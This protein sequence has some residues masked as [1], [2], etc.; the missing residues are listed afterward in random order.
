MK[1]LSTLFV[2]IITANLSAF[3]Y[4]SQDL[5]YDD[6]V[7][8]LNYKRNR[9][10]KISSGESLAQR[11]MSF[12]M[13]TTLGE[14]ETPNSLSYPL[15]QGFEIGIN[16][17]LGSQDVEGR[18]SFRY[19]FENQKSSERTSLRE[20]AFQV[21][22]TQNYSKSWDFTFGGGFSLRHLLHD[23]SSAAINEVSIQL[24]AMA[25]FE[26]RLSPSSKLA[27]EAGTRFPFGISGRDRLSLDAGIKL[28]TDLE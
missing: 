19:F 10:A 13:V 7:S 8:E 15:L 6:L 20:F 26:T 17:D 22:K 14:I 16:S 11:S 23:S 24:N 28:K 18:T 3:A 9:M 5:S 2:A 27:F 25:G 12:G 1:T 21:A 4:S